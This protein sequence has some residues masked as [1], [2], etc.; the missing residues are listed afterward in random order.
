MFLPLLLAADSRPE[1]N[2]PPSSL[3]IL[4]DPPL[5]SRGSMKDVCWKPDARDAILSAGLIILEPPPLPQ[6]DL[7]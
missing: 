6:L 5:W 4:L 7:K 1:E 2:P 3:L